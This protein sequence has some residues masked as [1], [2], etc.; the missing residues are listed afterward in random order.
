M[1]NKIILNFFTKKAIGLIYK[2][3]NIQLQSIK[4]YTAS[5]KTK[6]QVRGGG[7]KP[8]K[9]K[10]TG[11]ARA[12]SIRSPLWRSGGISFGPKF[13]SI[14]KKINKK[15]KKLALLYSLYLKKNNF[16]FINDKYIKN[17]LIL[18]INNFLKILKNLNII[19][20]T[21]SLILINNN[22][23]KIITKNI[24]INNYIHLNLIDILNYNQII[25]SKILLYKY[26]LNFF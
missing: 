4:N 15:E 7:R 2:C 3:Y 12:G 5:T 8:W 11:N 9:Q 21:K 18:K 6:G 10:G 19:F 22:I 16:I 26:L 14:T 20:T 25:T 13:K 24:K 23:N 1:I 17:F